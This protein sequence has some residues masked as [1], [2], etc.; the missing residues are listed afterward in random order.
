MWVFQLNSVTQSHRPQ[1]VEEEVC[2]YFRDA[3]VPVLPE[4]W[5]VMLAKVEKCNATVIKIDTMVQ[6]LQA[7]W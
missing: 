4:G 6:P 1:E 3:P 5:A 2:R 7:H